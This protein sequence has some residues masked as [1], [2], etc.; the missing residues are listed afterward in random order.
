MSAEVDYVL[1]TH[2]EEIQRL[3]LQHQ[4]WRAPV[5]D[6]WT[7][8]GINRGSRLVDFGCGP[9]FATLDAAA[10]VGPQGQVTAIERSAHFL[11]FAQKQADARGLGCVRFMQADLDADEIPLKDFDLAWCRWVAS[12]VAS[13]ERLINRIS[14]S[15]RGG[16]KA[17]LHEYQNY[18]SWQ[19][20]PHSETFAKFVE[21]V[22][23]S[24]RAAGGEPNIVNKLIPLLAPAGLAIVSLRPLISVIGPSHFNWQWPASFLGS[25]SRRL[26]ELKRITPAYAQRIQADFAILEKN[27]TALMVTPLV[28]EIIAEKIS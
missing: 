16:G 25:G 24:W 15:L 7:R 22:M 4:V 1:G 21:E 19:V 28:V 13:P 20:I 10:L 26:V 8:A 9:G 27:P 12:F 23:A 11:S 18:A 5:L 2:D 17:V 3:G 6:A 14:A